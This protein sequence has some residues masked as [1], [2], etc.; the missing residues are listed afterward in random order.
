MTTAGPLLTGQTVQVGGDVWFRQR[1][2]DMLANDTF[3][4]LAT[5]ADAQIYAVTNAGTFGFIMLDEFAIQITD[6][7]VV[8]RKQGGVSLDGGQGFG[9]A[10]AVETGILSG[11]IFLN[12]RMGTTDDANEEEEEW[13][14]EEDETDDTVRIPLI[15][16]DAIAA[17]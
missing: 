15:V 4:G 5:A 12:D 1:T 14:I 11:D 3:L 7:L 8:N 6:A 9:L 13:L 10:V 17:Q 16:A 2:F